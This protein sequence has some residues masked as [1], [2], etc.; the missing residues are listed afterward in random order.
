MSQVVSQLLAGTR[1][2]PGRSPGTARVP[3]LR[4]RPA[5][6]APRPAITTPREAPLNGR[7][8][9]RIEAVWCAGI[10][11]LSRA[12]FTS[13][14]WGEVASRSLATSARVR[15][16]ITGVVTPHPSRHATC[17]MRRSD[18][19]RARSR[20][21]AL[22]HKGR[23]GIKRYR[24]TTRSP[25]AHRCARG[26]HRRCDPQARRGSRPSI[27]PTAPHRPAAI[28]ATSG[29]APHRRRARC[30]G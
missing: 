5:G 28:R 25:A 18:A 30:D 27:R 20:Q 16:S 11:F 19:S 24:A 9:R 26:R 10:S 23:G 8:G 12:S 17:A 3:G 2:G 1:S 14:L 21:Q 13:P 15:G 22:S 29:R 7:G 6:A 4:T